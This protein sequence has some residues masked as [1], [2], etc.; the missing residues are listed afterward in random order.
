[1]GAA[2]YMQKPVQREQLLD[3]FKRLEERLE[4]VMP[5]HCSSSKTTR[6]SA[7]ASPSCSRARTSSSSRSAPGERGLDAQVTRAVRLHRDRPHAAG[8]VWLP[9]LEHDVRNRRGRIRPVI[10]YTGPLAVARRGAA[11]PEVLELDHRQGRA[12]AGAPARR[13]HALPC[14]RSSRRSRPIAR[15]CSRRRATAR[16]CSTGARSSSVEDD[17]RNIFALTQR[18]RAAGCQGRTIA[19]NGREVADDARERPRR[20]SWS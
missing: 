14:I 9:L 6:C 5:A 4:H 16:P 18:P 8:R 11:T 19:R 20:S 10:V 1:M 13:G 7:R 17:V 12:L 2:A 15:R 3:A